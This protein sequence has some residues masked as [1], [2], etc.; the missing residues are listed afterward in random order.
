MKKK[1]IMANLKNASI[2]EMVIDRCLSDKKRKYSMVDLLDA[3]NKALRN[4]GYAEVT[5]LNT[6]RGDIRAIEQRWFGYGCKIETEVH[7]RRRYYHYDNPTFSIYKTELTQE[8]LCKLNQTLLVLSKFQGLPQFQWIDELNARFKSVFMSSPE[9]DAIICFD[10]NI[11]AE[12]R[13]YISK[14][15]DAIVEKSVLRILYQRFSNNEAKEHIVH[16]YYLKEYNNRWFLLALDDAYGM[17]TTFALDRIKTVSIE[18]RKYIENHDIDFNDYFEDIVGVT[19]IPGN[20][21]RKIKLLV[22]SEQYPYISTKPLHGTQKVLE[23]LDDGSRILQ[24]E[25]RENY[26]L[27]QLLLSFGE[28]VV[29]IE[30]SDIQKKISERLHLAIEKYE[31]FR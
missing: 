25:V 14:L 31:R 8:D 20:E 30:P 26:E 16:P 21:V 12:G 1:T 7:G 13:Q 10:D 11:D 6:I 4:E 19:V 22:S 3:C 18:H 24:I 27:I 15:F 17:L 5:S 9:T 2:R 29:V 23:I 28:K